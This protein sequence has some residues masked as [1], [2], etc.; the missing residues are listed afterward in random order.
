MSK[1][2]ILHYNFDNRKNIKVLGF[3]F[4]TPPNLFCFGFLF[5]LLFSRRII[6]APPPPPPSV[7]KVNN[8]CEIISCRQTISVR[9]Y[10]L[11]PNNY[12]RCEAIAGG[13]LFTCGGY[14]KTTHPDHDYM[15]STFPKKT[16]T[17]Y[18]H[19]KGYARKDSMSARGVPLPRT[20]HMRRKSYLASS[21]QLF[22]SRTT[23]A[24]ARAVAM[25]GSS[26]GVASCGHAAC[27]TAQHWIL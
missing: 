2:I 18:K 5:C 1:Y 10:F 14:L 19:M 20:A 21:H 22:T 7:P 9:A 4:G 13:L 24:C 27:L 3:C 17:L 8:W 25:P 15:L 11:P 26:R 23:C 6:L 12:F 16:H